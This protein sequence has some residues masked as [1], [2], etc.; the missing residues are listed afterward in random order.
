MCLLW[1]R[2]EATVADG[3]WHFGNSWGFVLHF[4]ESP[5]AI[6]FFFPS[7]EC[8][9]SF[10]GNITAFALK[11]KVVYPINQKF[12]VRVLSSVLEMQ[13][14]SN[15]LEIGVGEGGLN[16]QFGVLFEDFMA[17]HFNRDDFVAV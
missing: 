6:C 9:P 5:H 14:T 8:E 2:P 4:T 15:V 1:A 3:M 10:N 11:A 7:Q 13:L 12:R 17:S 16:V